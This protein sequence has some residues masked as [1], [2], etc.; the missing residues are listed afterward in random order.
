[1]NDENTWQSWADEWGELTVEDALELNRIAELTC[2]E[3]S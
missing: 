3:D 2:E 1:M